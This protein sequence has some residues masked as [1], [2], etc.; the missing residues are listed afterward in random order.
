MSPEEARLAFDCRLPDLLREMVGNHPDPGPLVRAVNL[1]IPIIRDVAARA[2]EID[3]PELNIL[4]LRLALYE[5]D[6]RDR[7]AAIEHQRRRLAT[8]KDQTDE[9]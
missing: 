6:A 2:I 1:T 7:V 3:D 8:L 5:V 4:M 9:S